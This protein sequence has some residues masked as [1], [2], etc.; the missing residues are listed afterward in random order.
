MPNHFHF[1]IQVKEE[2]EIVTYDLADDINEL[3]SK[4]FKNFFL[5]YS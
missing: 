5:S 2:K 1:L 3:T 4:S